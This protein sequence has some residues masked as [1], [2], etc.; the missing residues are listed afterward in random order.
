MKKQ[1]VIFVLV[2]IVTVSGVYWRQL[3]SEL[4]WDS[5]IF[6]EDNQA[7]ITGQPVWEAF[8]TGYFYQKFSMQSNYYRPL[9]LMSFML[10]QKLWGIHAGIMR[11]I[12]L[13]I[14]LLGL[15]VLYQ[16]LRL[17][18]QAGYFP[19]IATLLFALF[20]L[21]LDN[22]M[23]VV[24]RGDLFLLLFSILTLLGLEYYLRRGKGVFLAASSFFYLLG[25]FSKESILFLFPVLI[26]YEAV[27]RK[28]INWIYHGANAGLTLIFF[29]IKIG[30]AGVKNPE[31]FFQAGLLKNIQL[32]LAAVGYYFRSMI[33][34]WTYDFFIPENLLFGIKYLIYGIIA[35][36]FFVFLV[37]LSRRSRILLVPLSLIFFFTAGHLVIVFTSVFQFKVFSRYMMIPA[38]GLIWIGAHCLIKLKEKPRL[39]VWLL[40][41]VSFIPAVIMSAYNYKSEIHF[42]RNAH[43]SFPRNGYILYEM[44]RSFRAGGNHLAAEL[45]LNQTLQSEITKETALLVSLMYAELEYQ[46]ARY[47]YVFRWLQSLEE[48]A[49]RFQ[50]RISPY[51]QTEVNRV[52]AKTYAARGEVGKAENLLRQSILATGDVRAYQDLYSLYAGYHMWDKAASLEQDM[53]SRSGELIEMDAGRTEQSLERLPAPEK[54]DFYIRHKNFARAADILESIPELSIDRKFTL[55]Q[56]Y[57]RMGDEEQAQRTVGELL[58]ENPEDTRLL[59]SL[60]N[61]YIT[62]LIRVQS[63]VPFFERS[64][65]LDP[66]QEDIQTLLIRLRENYLDKRMEVWPEEKPERKESGP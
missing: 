41:T 13:V 20:P 33:F 63:A 57:Y 53:V 19:E 24:G 61:F 54:A 42:W 44:A 12:N 29:G 62:Q 36:V 39:A 18:T 34:P 45:Y 14:Y 51:W 17:Q 40:L 35:I 38:L 25:L 6:L 10:E 43:N 49:G 5:R 16:F 7:L 4:I 23:W 65:E 46:R 59:N 27:K 56:L 2:L 64:L 60:G 47:E 9:T 50:A 15:M 31:M 28:K 37:W 1:T 21:N 32:T 8:D 66:G 3:D 11:G 58:R 55:I 52:R 30:F 26:V 22:I 48:L